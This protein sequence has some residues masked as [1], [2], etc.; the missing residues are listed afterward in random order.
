MTDAEKIHEIARLLGIFDLGCS[1][2]TLGTAKGPPTDCVECTAHILRMIANVIALTDDKSAM[3]TPSDDN[4]KARAL[5]V[6]INDMRR[7][8]S[9]DASTWA[10]RL[11]DVLE[12]IP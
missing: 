2:T 9:N 10:D 3:T 8:L 1:N 4:R 6:I 7:S 11:Q 5:M 12:E